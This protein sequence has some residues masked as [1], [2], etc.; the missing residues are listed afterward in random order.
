MGVAADSAAGLRLQQQHLFQLPGGGRR[1]LLRIFQLR[2]HRLVCRRPS[3]A[4]AAPGGR[5]GRCV[6]GRCLPRD[7]TR[8]PGETGCPRVH[9]RPAEKGPAHPAP[10]GPE[11]PAVEIDRLEALGE[12]AYPLFISSRN[13]AYMHVSPGF[14]GE[15]CPAGEKRLA[16]GGH[17][18]R[19][20]V[21]Y[22]IC[23]PAA[24]LVWTK[25]TRMA[26]ASA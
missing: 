5:R 20:T 7:G 2:G 3:G 24:A 8:Q 4:H 9:H 16:D 25:G 18:P 11:R 10:G 12:P 21:L 22:R 15:T 19:R 1:S 23:R 13:G 6:C 26:A 17:R 14:A